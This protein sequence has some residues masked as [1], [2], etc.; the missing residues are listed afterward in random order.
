MKALSGSNFAPGKNSGERL[1]CRAVG[2]RLQLA[3][4]QAVI[5]GMRRRIIPKFSIENHEAVQHVKPE[6]L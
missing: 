2:C 6:E 1:D 4:R 5:D 3:T